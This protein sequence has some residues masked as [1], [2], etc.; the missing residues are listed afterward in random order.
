MRTRCGARRRRTADVHH[1]IGARAREVGRM[2]ALKSALTPARTRVHALAR[3]R[4]NSARVPTRFTSAVTTPWA[5]SQGAPRRP[6]W[7]RAVASVSRWEC[8]RRPPLRWSTTPSGWSGLTWYAGARAHCCASSHAHPRVGHALTRALAAAQVLRERCNASVGVFTDVDT[9][10]PV[11]TLVVSPPRLSEEDAAARRKGVEEGLVPV[12]AG[13]MPADAVPQGDRIISV[14]LSTLTAG[15]R[16]AA[17][18]LLLCGSPRAAAG[19]VMGAAVVAAAALVHALLK[20]RWHTR[21]RPRSP[22]GVPPT[23]RAGVFLRTRARTRQTRGRAR[24]RLRCC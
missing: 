12:G 4:R 6:R 5:C 1:V 18:V 22:Q 23:G 3:D 9:L 20:V 8:W 10:A 19:A 21:V 13:E 17:L 24:I 7:R 2:R 15:L 16:A 14:G 11:V